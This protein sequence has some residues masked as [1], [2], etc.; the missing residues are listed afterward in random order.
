MM[1]ETPM[2]ESTKTACML[3][4]CFIVRAWSWKVRHLHSFCLE[5]GLLTARGFLV[6]VIMGDPPQ[7]R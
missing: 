4:H 3:Y 5:T 6:G 7:S 2:V 1:Y